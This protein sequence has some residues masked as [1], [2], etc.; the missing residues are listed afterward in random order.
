MYDLVM[1]T[2]EKKYERSIYKSKSCYVYVQKIPADLSLSEEVASCFVPSARWVF[3]G[4]FYFRQS[5]KLKTKS[6]RVTNKLWLM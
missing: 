6:E 4:S 1:I 5:E 3:V 2:T